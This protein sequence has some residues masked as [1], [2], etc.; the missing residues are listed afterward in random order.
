MKNRILY[1]AV[2]VF[3]AS[4]VQA[5]PA[6]AAPAEADATVWE[7]PAPLPDQT[8][9]SG[10]EPAAPLPEPAVQEEAEPVFGEEIAEYA[11]RFVGN[12]YQFGGSSLTGGTDCSGFTMAVYRSF[13]ID[14]PHSSRAQRN[15]GTAVG[16]LEE[17][18]PGDLICYSGHVGLYI[19]EGQIVHA[20]NERKGILISDAEYERILAIRRVI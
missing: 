5:S 20:L 18:Q 17:A 10:Q 9:V 7:T 14:L 16:S 8:D 19:G 3:L 15:A 12:P 11:L 2:F 4:L 13:G 6:L 1:T